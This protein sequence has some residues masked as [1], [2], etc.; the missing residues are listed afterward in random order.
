MISVI[1]PVYIRE[2]NRKKIIPL[3][4]ECIQSLRGYDELILQFDEKGEGFAKTINK[5]VERASGDWIALVND[6]T[7][8][9]NGSIKEMCKFRKILTL[10]V[11]HA[12]IP[13]IDEIK[14]KTDIEYFAVPGDYDKEYLINKGEN[15]SNIFV[16]GRPSYD[17][18]Y[19]KPVG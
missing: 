3:L 8:M 15:G 10:Y 13:V 2:S 16:V 1:I 6:D 12:A 9:L 14:T 19:K 4:E 5:G 11:P 17:F 7:R 18:F